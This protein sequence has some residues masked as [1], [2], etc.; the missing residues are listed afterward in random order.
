MPLEMVLNEHSLCAPDLDTARVWMTQFAG[1][2][3][4]AN[5]V[6]VGQRSKLWT[7]KEVE[8]TVLTKDYNGRDYTLRDYLFRDSTVKKEQREQIAYLQFLL[9]QAPYWNKSP[10]PNVSLASLDPAID[11]IEFTHNSRTCSLCGIGF[12][13]LRDVLAIVIVISLP[14]DECW[15]VDNIELKVI[16]ATTTSISETTAAVAHASNPNHVTVHAEWIEKRFRGMI[17][18]GNDLWNRRTTLFPSLRFCDAVHRQIEWLRGPR[19]DSVWE[20]LSDL[21]MYC[22]KW[23]SGDFNRNNLRGK[24]RTDSEATLQR[25]KQDRI[26]ECPDGKRRCFS[27]HVNLPFSRRLYFFP[28]PEHRRIIIGYVGPHL[29]T[30]KFN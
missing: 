3:Q 24:P 23:T 28:V 16:W 18:N 12:A 6:S 9:T 30:V 8:G 7:P 21:Q 2:L 25:F 13:Y 15:Q 10:Q 14:S 17:H 29:R 27:W 11:A 26:F 5:Q 20:R 1:T 19:L 4:K 22:E